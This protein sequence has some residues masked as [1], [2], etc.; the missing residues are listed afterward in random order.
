MNSQ[1]V[2]AS[3]PMRKRKKR[4]YNKRSGPPKR[5]A[6]NLKRLRAEA[7]KPTQDDVADR[8]GVSH[9]PQLESGHRRPGEETLR[10]LA[11]F[12]TEALGRRVTEGEIMGDEGADLSVS[13]YE[14]TL[15]EFLAQKSLSPE[16][17]AE[18]RQNAKF[19]RGKPTVEAWELNYKLLEISARLHGR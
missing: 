17:V 13:L 3:L 19:P 18:L 15:A 16:Q 6:A 5:W 4:P 12:Y 8:A 7:G 14:R 1:N 2:L 9:Y 11:A 10:K